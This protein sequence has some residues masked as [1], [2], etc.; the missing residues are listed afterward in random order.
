MDEEITFPRKNPKNIFRFFKNLDFFGKAIF[1]LLALLF[2]SLF[3]GSIFLFLRQRFLSG[4]GWLSLGEAEPPEELTLE[5]LYNQK[6]LGEELPLSED[7][8]LQ[9]S[10]RVEFLKSEGGRWLVRIDNKK[11]AYLANPC[12]R[13]GDEN[14]KKK[15]TILL[16]IENCQ[17][18][19]FAKCALGWRG[20]AGRVDGS[21]CDVILE[22]GDRIAI[23]W[24]SRVD[25]LVTSDLGADL[26]SGRGQPSQQFDLEEGESIFIVT[27]PGGRLKTVYV[28]R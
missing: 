14:F 17:G 8:C 25:F 11:E 23:V 9:K 24:D 13:V 15:P 21:V 22:S 1:G 2:V 26:A 19:H 5:T 16:T 20:V 4:R 28:E 7:G 18:Q 3:V 10:Y 6:G 12:S 27:D